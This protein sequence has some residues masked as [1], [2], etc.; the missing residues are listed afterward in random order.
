M[1][2]AILLGCEQ[3]AV[4]P[5][6]LAP[7]ENGVY[8]VLNEGATRSEARG[9]DT[10]CAVL[11]YDGKYTDAGPGQPVRYVAIDPSSFVPLVLEGEPDTEESDEGKTILSVALEEEYVKPLEEFTR[12]QLNGRIAI[13]IDGEI[14]TMH[15]VRRVITEG[16]FQVTRCADDACKMLRSKLME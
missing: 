12:A 3:D 4:Q 16:Q 1:A 7:V 15:K 2:A 13:L 6:D 8:A 11:A 10:H 5:Q 14:V 9:D